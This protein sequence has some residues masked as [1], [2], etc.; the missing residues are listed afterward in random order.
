MRQVSIQ[1]R[2]STNTHKQTRNSLRPSLRC[3]LHSKQTQL[4][5][6]EHH[7]FGEGNYIC[8]APQCCVCELKISQ[9]SSPLSYANSFTNAIWLMWGRCGLDG[10]NIENEIWIYLVKRGTYIYSILRPHREWFIPSRNILS[11]DLTSF[12]RD[13]IDQSRSIRV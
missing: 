9:G 5:P 4:D 3:A 7:P 12:L 8:I 1:N 11:L 2:H 13:L 6:H 10:R